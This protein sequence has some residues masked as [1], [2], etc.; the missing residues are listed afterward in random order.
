MRTSKVV[1]L[2][3]EF[4]DSLCSSDE[5]DIKVGFA[6]VESID[7]ISCM[8]AVGSRQCSFTFSYVRYE[9]TTYVDR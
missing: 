1:H 9:C 8:I 3:V 5:S 4:E 7:I 6:G 2:K